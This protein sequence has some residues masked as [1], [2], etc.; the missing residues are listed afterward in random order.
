MNNDYHDTIGTSPY[1]A[2]FNQPPPRQITKLVEFPE[3][4]ARDYKHLEITNRIL[5]KAELRKQ[6]Q[7]K[8]T[9]TT[10]IPYRR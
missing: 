6:L 9:Q 2:M 8:N 1:E 7:M 10:S 5:H 4:E 3:Q